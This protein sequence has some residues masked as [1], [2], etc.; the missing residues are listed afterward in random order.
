MKG[1]DLMRK[2]YVTPMMS[3]EVFQAEEYV[4]ACWTVACERAGTQYWQEDAARDVSHNRFNGGKGCGYAKNQVISSA[5]DGT[6][7][8][9]EVLTKGQGDLSCTITDSHWNKTTLKESDVKIGETVYWTTT[10]TDGTNRVWHHWGTVQSMGGG[11]AN[12]S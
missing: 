5:G 3:E 4:A 6:V 9:T 1:G 12:H 7:K 11:N 8:M 10:A 2:Q